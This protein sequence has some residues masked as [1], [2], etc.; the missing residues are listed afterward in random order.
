MS[1]TFI[2][3]PLDFEQIREQW[4]KYEL[5]DASI[6]KVKV[7]VT[8]VVKASAEQLQATPSPSSTYNIDFQNII[9]L[10]TNERGPPDATMHSPQDIL[11]H[12]IRDNIR[13][14]TVEQD[15]NEYLTDDNARILIQPLVMRVAKS[16]F[17]NNKGEPIYYVETQATMQIRAPGTPLPPPS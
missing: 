4:A 13:F 3:P 11:V 7:I 17:F 14:R 9:I 2:P 1:A 15:W 8:K 10:L 6:L 16:S 12:I 5:A